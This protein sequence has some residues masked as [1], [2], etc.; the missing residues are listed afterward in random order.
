MGGLVFSRKRFA[1]A[2]NIPFETYFF[3][4]FVRETKTPPGVSIHR[5]IISRTTGDARN[6]ASELGG[7]DKFLGP[8]M[9][10]SYSLVSRCF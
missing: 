5:T 4:R 9:L 6:A 10:D 1:A 8:R 3:D 2:M 7:A